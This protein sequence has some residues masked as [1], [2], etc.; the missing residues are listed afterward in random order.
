MH[1]SLTIALVGSEVFLV[2]P[3]L[4]GFPEHLD[5]DTTTLC[6]VDAGEAPSGLLVRSRDDTS[7][8]HGYFKGFAIAAYETLCCVS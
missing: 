3:V 2:F 4:K 7:R 5:D 6:V 8:F 1:Y